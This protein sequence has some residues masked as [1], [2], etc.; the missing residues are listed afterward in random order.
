MNQFP[1]TNYH[2]LNLNWLL[3]Q[4]KN[5]LAEWETTKGEWTAQEADN[6]EFKAYVTNYFDNL[7]LTQEISDK[8]D[9]LVEDGTLLR[10]LTE[11]EGEGSPLSDTVGEWL[12]AHITQE[13]GYVIDDTLTVQGA[14][15]DAK[16]AGDAINDLRSAF[17]I[18]DGVSMA[19]SALLNGANYSLANV[20]RTNYWWRIDIEAGKTYTITNTGTV[21]Y[22][23]F[24][25][26]TMNDS[27]TPE[28]LS[29]SAIAV[30]G[31]KSFTPNSSHK[32]IKFF[33]TTT[34]NLGANLIRSD[35]IYQLTNN[36][37]EQANINSN[38][39]R[40]SGKHT[41]TTDDLANI[42]SS[43]KAFVPDSTRLS[44]KGLLYVK[45]GDKIV[46]SDIGSLVFGYAFYVGDSTTATGSSGWLPVNSSEYYQEI[47]IETEGLMYLT[48]AKAS[49]QSATIS[50]S[51]FDATV[52]IYMNEEDEHLTDYI[53]SGYLKVTSDMI[54]QGQ[55]KQK[56][57]NYVSNNL[58]LYKMI[59]AKEGD[60]IVYKTTSLEVEFY[61]YIGESTTAAN[62][63]GWL[64][65]STY[66]DYFVPAD[67]KLC[68]IFRKSN[69]STVSVSDYDADITIYSSQISR[70]KTDIDNLKKGVFDE[71]FCKQIGMTPIDFE[72][73]S[74]S[75]RSDGEIVDPTR[76]REI[77]Y[78][79]LIND[80][81]IHCDTG[82]QAAYRIYNY[83]GSTYTDAGANTEGWSSSLQT[84]R[85][86]VAG[87]Y[88]RICVKREDNENISVSEANH[89]RIYVFNFGTHSYFDNPLFHNV[90]HRGFSTVAP[91]NTI[92]AFALARKLGFR[93]VETDVQFTASD[94]NNP[95]GV[96]VILHDRAINRTARNAD[97]TEISST[98]YIDDITY[99]EAA[100]YDYGIWKNALYE[101]TEIPTFE[102][103]ALWCKQSGVKPYIE[104]KTDVTYTQDQINLL[105]SIAKKYGILDKCTWISFGI[106]VLGYVHTAYENAR[107]G[108]LLHGDITA[109]DV[110][111][112]KALRSTNEV[113][114]LP[115]D[116]QHEIDT[117]TFA[118]ALAENIKVEACI[119][120][121]D[122]LF[123]DMDVTYSGNVTNGYPTNRK[124]W[125]SANGT[126]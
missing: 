103:F 29:G 47:T 91:E 112:L 70:N 79:E 114:F 14:A 57:K 67:G 3:G 111:N 46:I 4:M 43:S 77:G 1:G 33:S 68:I 32:Y 55:F 42:R 87:N 31:T 60:R 40:K 107:L 92:P 122:T 90:C 97:G 27:E 93:Y 34:G 12:A 108:Y 58:R 115:Y 36:A 48:F 63:S 28:T 101:G 98:I 123:S 24:A 102:E 76:L 61:Q 20:I 74:G 5:C 17:D 96:P 71:C 65:S 50:K 38:F 106:T 81:I 99:D 22:S 13:T 66:K 15:A 11:D 80:I 16:A 51:D 52:T 119:I 125:E 9:S 54:E 25:S 18:N 10:I 118:L 19:D 83:N 85:N 121:N 39:I 30:G 64:T 21:S 62:V 105:I 120:D 23:L 113:F 59:D 73:E 100:E 116:Y 84:T 72:Y 75:L 26:D 8:I 49:S 88:I 86:L 124:M 45:P 69:N 95:N 82:Y 117:S 104:L 7:D 110:T 109:T 56:K 94:T 41:I 2:D 53:T 6:A 126:L 35:S 37:T 44:L 89:V 78:Y